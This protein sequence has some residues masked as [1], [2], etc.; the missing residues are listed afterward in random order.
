M[1]I[2]IQPLR[3]IQRSLSLTFSP[4]LSIKLCTMELRADQTYTLD[5]KETGPKPTLI[6]GLANI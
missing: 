2:C 6:K 5:H 3:N 4:Q 1:K